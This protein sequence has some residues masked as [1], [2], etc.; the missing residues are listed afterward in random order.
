MK[1]QDRPG[2]YSRQFCTYCRGS[3]EGFSNFSLKGAQ[4][5]AEDKI[6]Q[7]GMHRGLTKMEAGEQMISLQERG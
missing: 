5:R 2:H 1:H 7:C 3:H 4:E 6:V